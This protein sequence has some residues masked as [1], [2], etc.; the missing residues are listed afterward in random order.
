MSRIF[1]TLVKV[2]FYAIK[3]NL[4]SIKYIFIISPF[5]IISKCASIQSKTFL[6]YTSLNGVSVEWMADFAGLG[7]RQGYLSLNLEF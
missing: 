4:Y 6:S 1:E 2:N 3:I 7:I 5:S